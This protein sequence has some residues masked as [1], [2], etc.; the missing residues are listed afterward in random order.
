VDA[1]EEGPGVVEKDLGVGALDS[2]SK[3]INIHFQEVVEVIK[4]L[5]ELIGGPQV[6]VL[7][8]LEQCNVI[9]THGDIF[10]WVWGELWLLEEGGSHISGSFTGCTEVSR[11]VFPSHLKGAGHHDLDGVCSIVAWEDITEVEFILVRHNHPPEAI[12]DVKLDEDPGALLIWAGGN[13]MDQAGEDMAKLGHGVCGGL[14]GVG[15]LI[16]RGPGST[17]NGEHVGE[18]QYHAKEAAFVG[19]GSN[20]ADADGLWE[21]PA[22]LFPGDQSGKTLGNLVICLFQEGLGCFRSSCRGVGPTFNGSFQGM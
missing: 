21:A 9:A 20:G 12:F 2:P 1:M 10:K 6:G 13:G 3:I 18:V 15:G 16:D 11:A 22:E 14:L 7:Q 5:G 4:V 8:L 17:I 19:N